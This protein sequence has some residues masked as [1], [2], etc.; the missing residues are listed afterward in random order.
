MDT[1]CQ[2]ISI[3]FL[4]I[5]AFSFTDDMMGTFSFMDL[6]QNG[7]TFWLWVFGDGNTSTEQHP[8]HT[9]TMPGDYEVCLM[10][11]NAAGID[12]VC[13]IISFNFLPIAAFS[14]TDDLLGTLNFTDLS[15]KQ[16]N[17]LVL[18]FW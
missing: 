8:V 2:S 18:G 14:F 16:P 4:P 15:Q 7:P 3:N 10:A 17:L 6:T 11:G 12:T 13:Q 1:V 5:A 9:Y